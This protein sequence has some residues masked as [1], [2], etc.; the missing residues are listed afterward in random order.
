MINF[1][2][3]FYIFGLRFAFRVH[4]LQWIGYESVVGLG[5]IY[6]NTNPKPLK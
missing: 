2:E 6:E 4:H 3:T 5:V 1:D